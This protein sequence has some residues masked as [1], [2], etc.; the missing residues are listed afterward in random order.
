M[1]EKVL[2][3]TL[4]TGSI[5][6]RDSPGGEER[7]KILLEKIQKREF[8]YWKTKYQIENINT[9]TEFLAEPLIKSF[10]PDRVLLI[11]T[12]KSSWTSFYTKFGNKESE[13][14]EKNIFTLDEIE[15][16][17]GQK[18]EGEK[19]DEIEKQINEIYGNEIVIDGCSGIKINVI[20]MRYG[21]NKEELLEN[22]QRLSR[23]IKNVLEFREKYEVAFD[24]T[25]SF[26][27]LPL[28]NL[29]V[30]NYFKHISSRYDIA[31][32]HIYYG[33]LD[34]SRE[35]DHIA[36]IVDLKDLIGVLDLTSGINEFKNTGNAV[37]LLSMMEKNGI[38]QPLKQ[39]DWATQMNGL[40]EIEDALEKLLS[41]VSTEEEYENMQYTD[42]KTMLHT[43][44]IDKF[45]KENGI[46]I[47]TI[48]DL[49]KMEIAEKQYI[50]AKWYL[51]QNRY[52]QAVATA[53][54]ALRSYLVPMYL[55][56]K[57]MENTK[58]NCMNEDNRKKALSRLRLIEVSGKETEEEKEITEVLYAVEKCR[59]PA[60]K[61][62]DKFAHNL[63]ELSGDGKNIIN[64]QS[65]KEI[66]EK[67][68]SALDDLRKELRIHKEQIYKVYTK[69]NR[70]H[71]QK[72][73]GNHIRLII[74]MDKE[75]DYNQYQKKYKVYRLP[76]A[77]IDFLLKTKQDSARNAAFLLKYVRQYFS[78]DVQVVFSGLPLRE[79]LH[80]AFMFQKEGMNV[81]EDMSRGTVTPMPKLSYHLEID[82]EGNSDR[83]TNA[84]EKYLDMEPE[85][86]EKEKKQKET[87]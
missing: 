70:K 44:L 59:I 73:K 10:Q 5:L 19:L 84:M 82:L 76:E 21:I 71:I 33:N 66:I 61:V 48:E 32:S 38:W 4:G 20:I 77:F 9:E 63:E 40:N 49:K 43:V 29:V 11:G 81:F 53:L 54:E 14:W 57:N 30:L 28:Y 18:T 47:E 1:G 55:K 52:G 8:C 72:V 65:S 12:V 24:I 46:E 31:I 23:G 60:K 86:I 78:D 87:N 75:K 6:D 3:L 68:F 42:L 7:K 15:Y 41:A 35:T 45:F 64:E 51:Q 13:N 58:E 69:D 39:F 36:Y 79:M 26:R 74:T 62:R 17:H 34:V 80:Y 22:Y 16:T 50:I 85:Y 27:S 83:I 25:H 2:I 56:F 67:F 37:T